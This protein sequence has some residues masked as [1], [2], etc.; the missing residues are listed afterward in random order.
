VPEATVVRERATPWHDVREILLPARVPAELADVPRATDPIRVLHYRPRPAGGT[1]RPLVLL[2]PVLGNGALLVNELATAVTRKGYHA[3]MVFRK[4]LEFHPER[5]LEDAEAEIRL[6]VMRSKQVVDWFLT[7]PDVDGRRLG[8]L[9][10]SAGAIVNACVAGADPRLR[11]HVFVLAGGPLADVLVDSRERRFVRYGRAIGA[12]LGWTPD[13]VRAELRRTIR[14]DP[15]LLAPQVRGDVLLFLARGDTSVPTRH[16]WTLW[17]ALGRPRVHVLP[18][19][20]RT[21]FAL[22]GWIT[23]RAADFLA[24][25]LGPP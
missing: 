16:G 21:S 13:Q 17:E 1:P 18:S 9:G 20:H 5:S 24:D 2:S 15:V 8:T 6:V 7:Q 10:V 14:T 23:G 19:G 3:A 11:A 4:D 22:L 25:R 12:S